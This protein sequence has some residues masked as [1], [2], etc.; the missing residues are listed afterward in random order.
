M[1]RIVNL[2][3]P[4]LLAVNR[5]PTPVLS[6]ISPAKD[7]LPDTEAIDMVPPFVRFGLTSRVLKRVE[8]FTPVFNPRPPLLVITNFVLPEEEA[9]NISPFAEE[10]LTIRVALLPASPD[11][12]RSPFGLVT[13]PAPILPVS[14]ERYR[15]W[16]FLGVK[17]ISPVVAPPR[18]KV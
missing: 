4:D 7:V 9:V 15:V 11:K 5:S 17:D 3:A 18:V 10:L 6:T 8:L 13:V 2:V 16:I 12:V 1:F 14:P